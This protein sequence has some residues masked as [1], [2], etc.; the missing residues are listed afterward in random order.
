[1]SDE[2]EVGAC[3]SPAKKKTTGGIGEVH[4]FPLL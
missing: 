2:A 1:V 4:S 3:P